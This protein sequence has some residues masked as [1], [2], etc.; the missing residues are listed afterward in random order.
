MERLLGFICSFT[1]TTRYWSN[2]VGQYSLLGA[3]IQSQNSFV[4]RVPFLLPKRVRGILFRRSFVAH[5]DLPMPVNRV[6]YNVLR[7]V[8]ELRGPG[9]N[10]AKYEIR[11]YNINHGGMGGEESLR[12]GRPFYNGPLMEISRWSILGQGIIRSMLIW[13]IATTVCDYKQTSQ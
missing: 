12:T 8:D 2:S 6:V 13:H 1:L 5:Q 4:A 7:H 9:P 10:D 11:R 3:C